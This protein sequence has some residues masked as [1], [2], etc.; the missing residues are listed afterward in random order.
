MW[1]GENRWNSW[2]QGTSVSHHVT[3]WMPL[4]EPPAD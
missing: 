3:H 2:H 1:F 4:P